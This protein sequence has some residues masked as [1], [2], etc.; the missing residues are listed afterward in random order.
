VTTPA[1]PDDG[2]DSRLR[3]VAVAIVSENDDPEGMGRVKLTY[4]WRDVE[5][6]SYWARIA[7]PMA[8]DDRGTYF[9]PEKDDEV[10]VAFD[11]GDIRHPYVIGSLW[12]GQQPPPA[13]NE[14][15]NDIR[16]IRSR[17]GHELV[18]DDNESEGKVAVTSNGGHSVVLDDA[19]GGSITVEDKGGNTITLDSAEGSITLSGASKLSIQAPMLEFK[20]DGNATLEA[21]GV[22][23][24]KGALVNIN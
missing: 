2:A 1:P 20:A 17:S 7:V 23:N 12:N 8:G 21:S 22:L 5:D 11:N 6:E 3:G 14:G 13:D 10:L 9:L 15:S 18:F 4:P 16:K 24:L 19:G